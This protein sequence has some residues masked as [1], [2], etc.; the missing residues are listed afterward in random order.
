MQ[1]AN[2][3]ST[4]THKAYNTVLLNSMQICSEFTVK[5]PHTE[6]LNRMPP[7]RYNV[8]ICHFYVFL[9]RQ[10]F[11]EGNPSHVTHTASVRVL[12]LAI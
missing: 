8:T 1:H 3:Q 5:I 12:F 6:F 11:V 2:C 7:F 10:K 4:V 9:Q